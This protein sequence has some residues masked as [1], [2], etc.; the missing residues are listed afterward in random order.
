MTTAI[1]VVAVVGALLALLA[2]PV[3]VAFRL[4]GIDP[5]NGQVTI[6]WLFGAVM[7]RIPVFGTGKGGE[8]AQ[9]AKTAAKARTKPRKRRG[10]G[11]IFAVLRQAD[12]R[13]RVLRLLRDLFATARFHEL[14]LLLRLGLG[15]PADTGRLWALLGPLAAAAQNLRDADVRIEPE[16]VDA[17]LEFRAAGQLRL[18]PLQ[19]VVL[20][21]GFV[22]SP[23]SIRAWRTLASSHA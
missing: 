22:L 12:F 15:D 9:G 1:F 14:R 6:R 10:R 19:Y 17:A 23:V 13:R 4:E 3:D 18:I 21:I 7:L 2:V 16:F 5:L 11:N 20:T 8:A